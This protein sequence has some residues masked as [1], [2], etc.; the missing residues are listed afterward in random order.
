MKKLAFL[1][2]EFDVLHVAVMGFEA[3]ADAFQLGVAIR[4]HLFHR[5]LLAL[6]PFAHDFGDRLRRT[7][8]G[9]HVFALCIHQEFA[10]QNLLAGRGI[11]GESDARGA[12]IAAIAEYHHLD[13][14]RRTPIFGM[15]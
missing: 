3:R 10:E 7:D 1:H 11:A 13:V 14:D 15:L 9:D 12:G 2:R 5:R 8:A 4:H 6:Q